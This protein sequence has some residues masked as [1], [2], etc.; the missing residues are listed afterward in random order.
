MYLNDPTLLNY[1]IWSTF[2]EYCSQIQ[3]ERNLRDSSES[4]P[5]FALKIY[6]RMRFFAEI[7]TQAGAKLL[8]AF[9][10]CCQNDRKFINNR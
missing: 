9:P 5:N 10:C 1:Y 2:G 4:T 6:T 7:K 8:K 3:S